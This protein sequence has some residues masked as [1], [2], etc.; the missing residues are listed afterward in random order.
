MISIETKSLTKKF[1]NI[2]TVN[3]IDFEL[4]EQFYQLLEV[5]KLK[6]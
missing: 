5:L 1:K 3:G 4:L 2:I 6:A